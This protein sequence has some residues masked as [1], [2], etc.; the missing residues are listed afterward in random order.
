MAVKIPPGDDSSLR[1]GAG[2]DL[3][4]PPRWDWRQ[5]RLWK[6]FRIVALGTGVI[7]DEGLCRRKGRSGGATRGPHARAARAGPAKFGALC[8]ILNR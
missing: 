8:E 3:L 1:L 6:V 7:L 4:N 5:R 2:G